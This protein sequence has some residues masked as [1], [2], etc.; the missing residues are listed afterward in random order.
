MF[1]DQGIYLWQIYLKRIMLK[2]E[3]CSGAIV[4]YWGKLF[5][6]TIL[7]EMEH[8]RVKSLLSLM[9][10]YELYECYIL[11]EAIKY[12]QIP[13]CQIYINDSFADNP[14]PQSK[15]KL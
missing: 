5:H 15:D 14:K 2:K 11:Q 13:H 10:I 9:K 4:R 6:K 7:E 3:S 12:Y 1:N 8:C